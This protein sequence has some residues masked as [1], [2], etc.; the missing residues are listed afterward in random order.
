MSAGL[1]DFQKEKARQVRAGQ[2]NLI[3]LIKKYD[4]KYD[5]AHPVPDDDALADRLFAAGMEMAVETGLWVLDTQKV[6]RFSEAEIWRYLDNYH[7]PLVFGYGKDQVVLQPRK[8]ESD[9][10]PLVIGG[11]AGSAVTEGEVYV[12][13]MM[14]FAMEPTNDMLAGIVALVVGYALNKAWNRLKI[15]YRRLI[16]QWWLTTS[17]S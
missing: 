15:T 7:T 3:R 16:G 13:H 12:K 10:R 11:G 5:P 4:I 14:D 17:T 1:T 8:P 6:A 2:V 9:V